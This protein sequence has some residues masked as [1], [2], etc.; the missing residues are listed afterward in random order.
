[1][2][3]I[4]LYD[5]YL[6]ILGGGERYVLSILKVFES[7]GYECSIFWNT[8]VTKEMEQKFGIKF[9]TLNFI[10]HIFPSTTLKTLRTLRTFNYFLYVTDGSYFFSSAKH[11]Y[12]YAM[13]PQE[14][15]YSKNLI[16]RLK[17]SNYTFITHSKFNEN[18]LK[19]WGIQTQLLYPYIDIPDRVSLSKKEKIILCVGRFFKHLHSKRHDLAIKAFLLL[20][21]NQKF[22]YYKLIIAGGLQKEDKDYFNSLKN[23]AKND[24]SILLKPNIGFSELYKLYDLSTFYW[25]FAGFGIDETKHPELVEHMGITPLEAMAHGVIS[26]CYNAG[27]PKE[28][29]SQGENGFLFKSKDELIKQMINIVKKQDELQSMQIK[30]IKFAGKN[31]SYPVFKK[32][33]IKL[34][35]L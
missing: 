24:S 4:A 14:L 17:M 5:P 16:N 21:Q 20:K 33:V 19:N 27:G 32:N 12:I 9:H 23:L 30:G 11:N 8:D 1:M 29:I 18:R 26:F 7:H 2:K 22:Q 6:N 31:F 15:L 13:V 35:D 3:K 34:F 25:H 28:T 10:P